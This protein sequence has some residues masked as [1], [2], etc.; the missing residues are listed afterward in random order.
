MAAGGL[1]ASHAPNLLNNIKQIQ[2]LFG[3]LYTA[4]AQGFISGRNFELIYENNTYRDLDAKSPEEADQ[5]IRQYCAAHPLVS[6]LQA[7]SS[8]F[9]T[10]PLKKISR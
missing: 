4:W 10:L 5:D 2:K 1:E 3:A 8:L 7:A 9:A 6:F